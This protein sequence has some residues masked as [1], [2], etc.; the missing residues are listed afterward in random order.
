MIELFVF[1]VSLLC[2]GIKSVV[3]IRKASNMDVINKLK[4]SN[5]NL[6]SDPAIMANILNKLL[7]NVSRNINKNI[8][9]SYK[10]PVHFMGDRVGN[11]FSIAPLVPFEISDIISALKSEKVSWAK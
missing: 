10:S 4:D 9:R 1:E 7:I 3:S 8:L 5:G 2:S 11:S 6:T